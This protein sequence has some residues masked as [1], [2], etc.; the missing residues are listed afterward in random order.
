MAK[1][2]MSNTTTAGTPYQDH[3]R[4]PATVKGKASAALRR[5][6]R[7][8]LDERRQTV[9]MDQI[10]GAGSECRGASNLTTGEQGPR[11]QAFMRDVFMMLQR[12]GYQPTISGRR[13]KAKR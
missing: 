1:A 4:L 11:D 13:I 5:S 3:G 9:G 8:P 10:A 6:L 2:A 12:L 7:S